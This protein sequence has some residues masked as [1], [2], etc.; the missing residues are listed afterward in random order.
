MK[1]Y[2]IYL[3]GDGDGGSPPGGIP[4]GPDPLPW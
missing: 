3:D 2:K 4:N 1:R